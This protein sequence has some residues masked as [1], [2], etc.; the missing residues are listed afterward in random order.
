MSLEAACRN[1]VQTV[2]SG[3]A[4]GVTGAAVVAT[5]G[6]VRAHPHLRHGRHLDGRRGLRRRPTRDHAGDER[7]RLPRA[8]SRRR[9]GEHRRRRRLDR[10][11]RGGDRGAPRR[12]QER[13]RCP[14]PCVLRPRRHGRDRDGRQRR[15]RAPSAAAPR[16]Q[17]GAGRGRRTAGGARASRMRAAPA[18]RRPHARSWTW[19]TKRCSARCAS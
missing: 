19:S 7:R 9:R 12:P 17:H 4:G 16:R 6:R 11:H 2:L 18:S 3:P 1:P 10:I 15:P 13:R 8:S 14:G 5:A